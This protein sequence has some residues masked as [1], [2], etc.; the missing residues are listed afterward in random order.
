MKVLSEI[1]T[2][3]F[4][5]PVVAR[6]FC[7]LFG[8]VT[9]EVLAKRVQRLLSKRYGPAKFGLF[10]SI[11]VGGVFGVETNAG[12]RLVLKV[13]PRRIPANTLQAVAEVQRRLHSCRFP[14]AEVLDDLIDAGDGLFATVMRY[15]DGNDEDGHDPRV[16]QELAAA[17]A[18]FAAITDKGDFPLV[19]NLVQASASRRLWPAPHKS[20]I[21][22]AETTRGAGFL[23]DRALRA[24]RTL[25]LAEELPM[26]LAHLD[27][28]VKNARF[29]KKKLVAVFD[30]DSLGT[31]C[32][33]ASVGK[34]AAQFTA[35]WDIPTKITPSSDEACAF[36]SEYEEARGRKLNR[37]ERKVA[38]AAADW[39]IAVTARQ[40]WGEGVRDETNTFVGLV[41]SLG[42]KPL[43]PV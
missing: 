27:W 18:R 31:M 13:Y 14:V 9:P 15:V 28:G 40:E 3:E 11:S 34:A 7:D 35:N 37:L 6:L 10:A 30:W 4:E 32:E 22:L 20:T 38:S 33:A 41:R 43:I 16:R 17:L 36:L 26:R 39:Q 25:A 19:A 29:R 12:D 24:R 8:P 2:K 5:H 23:R 1:I 42:K 21:R